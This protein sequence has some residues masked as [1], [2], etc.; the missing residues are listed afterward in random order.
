[1]TT[2]LSIIRDSLEAIGVLDPGD[3]LADQDAER[4]LTV[5]NDMLDSWSNESLTTF[6]FKQASFPLVV[7]QSIYT[8]G[9][10]GDINIPRPIRILDSPGAAYMLDVNSN[11]YP[12]DVVDIMSWN[13]RTTSAV[14]ANIPDTLWYDNQMPLAR[15]NVWPI[16]N[17]GSYTCYFYSYTQLTD[18][19]VLTTDVTFP[20]GY[21][22]AIKSNLAMWLFPYFKDGDPSAVLAMRADRTLGAI[23]RSNIR[24]QIAIYEP[25]LISRGQGT[26]NIRTDR[27]Y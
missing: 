25:E 26:Y 21:N 5:L 6:A 3:P 2:A 13:L 1:M 14:N 11:K 16:P 15:L 20:P 23:K 10:G 24:E 8:V 27:N 18:F 4:G 12:I 9:T 22:A 17:T 19:T 7:G